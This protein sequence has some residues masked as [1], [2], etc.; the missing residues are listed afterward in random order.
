MR[1]GER[2]I[3]P[4]SPPYV[5]AEIGVN[6]D[7]S[8]DRALYL[9]DAAAEASADAIKLQLFE[10]DRLLSRAAK[11]AAYQKDS[12]AS[13]PF[14]MLRGLELSLDQMKPIVDRAHTLGLHA[15][16]TIFSVELVEMANRMGGGGWDAYKTASPDIINKRLI[17]ALRETGRPLLLSCGAATLQEIAQAIGWLGD[18]PHILMQCVSAY[19]TPDEHAALAGRCAMRSID[20]CAL[21]YSD[22]TT[23]VDTGSLA[24]ASGARVLE[25]HLTHDRGAEGPDHAA[26]LDPPQFAEYV[27]LARRAFTM[28]GRREK[29][30]LEIE[31]D[32]RSVSRQSL[33]AMHPLPKGHTLVREDL[34]IKR[35]GTG[36]PPW[37]L[38]RVL[39]RRMVR[40]VE[41]DMPLMEAD[42]E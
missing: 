28:L 30:V 12:G 37:A 31:Q 8:V 25:K 4:D 41:A 10:T 32:V 34:T 35:P 13:D 17:D 40:D 2:H 19:P 29:T 5:I 21:G 9:V 15:I 39:G 20:A 23:A 1:I 26:S 36:L 27:R 6:H 18:H 14:A 33:T 22:H 24:V 38:E 11:L 16:V 3:G 7:G 42:I